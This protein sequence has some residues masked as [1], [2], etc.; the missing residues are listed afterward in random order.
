MISVDNHIEFII[1]TPIHIYNM[2]S[3]EKRCSI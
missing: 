1:Y 3:E 2:A